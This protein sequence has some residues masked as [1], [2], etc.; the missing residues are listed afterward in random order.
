MTDP[1]A[2]THDEAASQ[3]GPPDV[4]AYE[5]VV[6]AADHAAPDLEP[7]EVRYAWRL[8][9]A[10]EWARG[11]IAELGEPR[12][13]RTGRIWTP[14]A[15]IRSGVF[16]DRDSDG[17]LLEGLR[18]TADDDQ[19]AREVRPK[20]PASVVKQ[21]REDAWR[22]G[23][24]END[25]VARSRVGQRAW[26][27]S[28]RAPVFGSRRLFRPRQAAEQAAEASL[29]RLGPATNEAGE[30]TFEHVQRV[31]LTEGRFVADGGGRRFE[32]ERVLL[33][34]QADSP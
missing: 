13:A 4:I 12:L 31:T 17:T 21:A 26:E 19:T 33:D 1:Q 8:R 10:R 34:R 6:Y 16:T 28:V 30:V 7:V 9:A 20:I 23:L 3:A 25:A 11:R 14:W 5:I 24:H 2:F 29:A 27:L 15:Q 18:F 22:R 32:R